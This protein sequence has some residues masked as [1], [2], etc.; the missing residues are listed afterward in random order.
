MRT[1]SRLALLLALTLGGCTDPTSD[2]LVVRGEYRSTVYDGAAMM[3]SHEAIPALE[4]PAMQMSLPVGEAELLEGL[5]PGDKV[6]LTLQTEP[7]LRI[8]GVERLAPETPLEL[9]P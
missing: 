7:R 8:V 5:Q 6:A 4:M 1:A 3:V 2:A 9:A